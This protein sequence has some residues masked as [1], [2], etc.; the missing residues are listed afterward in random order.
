[1]LPLLSPIS[2]GKSNDGWPEPNG[3]CIYESLFWLN[4][5]EWWSSNS[6]IP[7]WLPLSSTYGL[8]NDGDA[9]DGWEESNPCG[10]FS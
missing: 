4:D 8:P 6:R 5:D 2:V 9:D 7:V 1:M 10:T 3:S